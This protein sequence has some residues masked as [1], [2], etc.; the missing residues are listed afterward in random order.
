[1]DLELTGKTAIVTG[2]SRGIGRATARQ[3]ALEGCD[4]AICAR[5]EGPLKQAAAELA[6]ESGRRPRRAEAPGP[7]SENVWNETVLGQAFSGAG[8]EQGG[9]DFVGAQAVTGRCARRE[10]RSLYAHS[11]FERDQRRKRLSCKMRVQII[12]N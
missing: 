9:V 3:L 2:A 6:K 10:T 7:C 1:V 5:T 12:E 8:F 11:D 4:V